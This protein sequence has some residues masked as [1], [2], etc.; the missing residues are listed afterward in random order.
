M[1]DTIE[2]KISRTLH[3]PLE[4]AVV[5]RYGFVGT[6]GSGKSS[7]A[8]VLAEEFLES[9]VQIVAIDPTGTWWGLRA[10]RDDASKPSGLRIVV[11]GGKNG[12]LPLDPE[13]GAE[14]ARWVVEQLP[15]VIFDLK[16]IRPGKREKFVEVFMRELYRL[17][18]AAKERTPLHIFFE[19]AQRWAAQQPGDREEKAV[20][21]LM[22]EIAEMIRNDGVGL[23]F[24][25]QAPQAVDKRVLNLTECLFVHQTNGK[26]ERKAILDWAIDKAV[27]LGDLDLVSMEIGEAY[28]WSPRWLKVLEKVKIRLKHTFYAG[29]TLKFGERSANVAPPLPEKALADL[30]AALKET[31]KRVVEDDPKAL[32]QEIARLKRE[33]VAKPAAIAGPPKIQI[34]KVPFMPKEISRDLYTAAAKAE[35]IAGELQQLEARARASALLVRDAMRRFAELKI[36]GPAQAAPTKPAPAKST[37]ATPPSFR[38]AD[39]PKL[40]SGEGRILGTLAAAGEEGLDRLQL[41]V[42]TIYH[43]NAGG[44]RNVLSAL[45]VSGLV[46]DVG[47]GVAISPAG[48]AAAKE[49][50]ARAFTTEE[51]VTAWRKKISGGARRILD[52]LLANYEVFSRESLAEASEF[53]AGGGGFRNCLSELRVAG[54]L[55]EDRDGISVTSILGG[56]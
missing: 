55:R 33:V 35:G 18:G 14:Y 1:S 8:Q 7:S 43:C 26:H 45:R 47:A 54:L 56:A 25:T 44:F 53:D 38:V 21:Y 48:R 34:E 49:M 17:K 46:E 52:A 22:R 36:E 50:G 10:K 2:L 41:A 9:H 11:I 28:V 19:E 12:D 51:I 27:D 4:T 5:Q 40:G 20:A 29:S 39:A 42:R 31:S 3:I 16:G 15:S 23:S 37:V 13:R 30:E 24:I 6:V 32:R